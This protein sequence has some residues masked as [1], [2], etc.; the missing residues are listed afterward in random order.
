MKVSALSIASV[1]IV[2]A[3]QVQP[4]GSDM[5]G[6]SKSSKGVLGIEPKPVLDKACRKFVGLWEGQDVP[7]KD[8]IPVAGA[9]A[10]TVKLNF[11]CKN[12]K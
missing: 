12:S 10:S 1:G 2:V 6:T 7:T 3:L 8:G 5:L 11:R 4:R 9:D